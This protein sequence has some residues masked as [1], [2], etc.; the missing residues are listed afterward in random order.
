MDFSKIV[1]YAYPLRK[2]VGDDKVPRPCPTTPLFKPIRHMQLSTRTLSRQILCNMYTVL[3]ADTKIN[4]T[5]VIFAAVN[6]Y[7]IRIQPITDGQPA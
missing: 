7:T 2:E 5:G 3:T 6:H 1:G 4:Y